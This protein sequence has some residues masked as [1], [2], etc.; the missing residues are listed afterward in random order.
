MPGGGCFEWSVHLVTYDTKKSM[1]SFSS[2]RNSTMNLNP[3]GKE[4][5]ANA[6]ME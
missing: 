4:R 1:R 2:G 3:E 5:E 6:P